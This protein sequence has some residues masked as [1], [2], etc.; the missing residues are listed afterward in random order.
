MLV[1]I[2]VMILFLFLAITFSLG[3]GSSLIADYNT[4]QDEEKAKI[5][6]IAL[7]KF[8]GKMMFALIFSMIFWLVSEVLQIDWLFVVGTILFICIIIF[9]LIYAN[10]GERFKKIDN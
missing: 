4:M 10:T 5:D 1:V 7:S 3:K 6:Q 8:I 9:A 2:F